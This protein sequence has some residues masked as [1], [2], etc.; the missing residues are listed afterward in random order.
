[1]AALHEQYRPRTWSEVV[2]QKKA[3][4]TVER[5]RQRGALAGRAFWI[6][7]QSGTG[8]TTIARLIAAEVAESFCIDEIDG[9]QVTAEVLDALERNC[10][11]RSFGRGACLIVNEAHGLRAPIIRRLL[12]ILEALPAW[13]TVVF[14]TTSEAQESLFEDQLDA[15]PLLSRCTVIPL[16]RRDLAKAFAYRAL[17]IARAEGLDGQPLPAYVKLAQE[18]R[19]NLRAMLSAI[20]SGVMLRGGSAESPESITAKTCG[21]TR[22]VVVTTNDDESLTLSLR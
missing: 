13:V 5:L 16:A 20:E 11:Q 22:P 19:N 1:M 4:E 10:R 21:Q 9:G 6:S 2:G 14:T 12:V 17:T 18:H 7:G 3:F 8:K 15:H